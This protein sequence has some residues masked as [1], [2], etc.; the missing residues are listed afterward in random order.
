M[1]LGSRRAEAFYERMTAIASC[2]TELTQG[3]WDPRAAARRAASRRCI[4]RELERLQDAAEF[5]VG[6][7]HLRDPALG[8]DR[9]RWRV[10]RA[11]RAAGAARCS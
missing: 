5:Q 9:G 1:A 8:P 2:A 6:R 11:D 10:E 4:G 7:D 3:P